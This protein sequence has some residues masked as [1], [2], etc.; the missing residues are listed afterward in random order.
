MGVY[1]LTSEGDFRAEEPV[2]KHFDVYLDGNEVWTTMGKVAA[3]KAQG[4]GK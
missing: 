4:E 2:L 3:L 1:H